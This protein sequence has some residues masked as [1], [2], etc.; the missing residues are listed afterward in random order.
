MTEPSRPKPNS[1]RQ[2][3][4][5]LL[6]RAVDEAIDPIPIS[7]GY[8][9]GIVLI[10]CAMLMLPLLYAALLLLLA[11]T[12]YWHAAYIA[13]LSN[14][15]LKVPLDGISNLAI[16][17]SLVLLPVVLLFLIKPLFY[18]DPKEKGT[19]QRLKESAEPFLFEYITAVCDSVGAPVPTSIRVNCE[20]N[21]S[22]SL[23]RGFAS[24][25]SDDLTL[26]IGLP[27]VAGMTVRELTGVLAHEFG[28]FA[29]TAGLRA[30]FVT[31]NINYWFWRATFKRDGW[32]EQLSNAS[33][34]FDI[35]IVLFIYLAQA[36]I[37]MTRQVLFVLAW[38]GSA[39]SCL[40]M[41]QMEFDAD[42]Y[43]ARM[44]GSNA[45]SRSCQRLRQLGFADYMAMHDLQRFYD[46]RRLADNLPRLIVSN[47][48]HITPEIRK[49]LRDSQRQ[50][51]TGLFDTHP[52]DVDRI[53]NA[54]AEETD[55]IWSMPPDLENCPATVLFDDFERL[56]RISTLEF[57]QARLGS[58]FEKE[59]LTS[60]DKLISER[61]SEYE[62][63]KALDRYFQVRLP[64]MQPLPIS[65]V[66]LERPENPKETAQSVKDSREALLKSVPEYRALCHRLEKAE[67]LMLR[68]G[69]AL[70][71]LDCR[72]K[73]KAKYFDLP[74][75][76]RRD[77]AETHERAREGVQN[78]ASRLMEFESNA[79]HRLT[80][81]LQLL[82]LPAITSR[83]ENG[84]DTCHE[85]RRM[86]PEALY[87][88]GLMSELGTMRILFRRLAALYGQIEKNQHNRRLYQEIFEQMEKLH[89]RLT[90]VHRQMRGRDY[91]LNNET[92]TLSLR[93][94]ALPEVPEQED[95]FGL[96]SVT[97]NLYEKVAGLQVRL[98]ARLARAAEQVE[99]IIGLPP[100]SEPDFDHVDK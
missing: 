94:Y 9:C 69:E 28:H 60:T 17:G 32:D 45:F 82:N 34:N 54:R 15:K 70:A 39:I 40:L 3:I 33:R 8:R 68:T 88:S 14:L 91:P 77:V 78:L 10:G 38:L 18:R 71:C 5:Q 49:A 62:A 81:A 48:P 12:I 25:F 2:E 96:V 26:T 89:T 30:S 92:M 55:G 67:S 100:L 75:V 97:Q 79:S 37:W 24:L 63:R 29:Q 4:R 43:E 44:V 53:A 51:K 90:S 46:E 95:L 72:L 84:D 20:V 36:G 35:R 19:P 66:A 61:D 50:Q 74:T 1:R 99:V 87:I 93:S 56:C 76:R 22:A 65:E 16:L 85:M 64:I 31:S 7:I 57:Y 23:R 73:I 13:E 59:R 21:A 52:A 27:L 58:E 80:N 98:F 41:R 47:I 83:M 6:L 42:R 86:V 11:H